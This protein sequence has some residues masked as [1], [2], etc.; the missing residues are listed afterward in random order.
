VNEPEIAPH[1]GLI[2]REVQAIFGVRLEDWI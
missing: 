2:A 1:G